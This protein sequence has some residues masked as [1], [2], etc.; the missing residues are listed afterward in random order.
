MMCLKIDFFFKK[1]STFLRTNHEEVV[2]TKDVVFHPSV[3]GPMPFFYDRR[4][5][6]ELR[7]E[8][9]TFFV[10]ITF[11]KLLSSDE[12]MFGIRVSPSDIIMN[13]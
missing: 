2:Y 13:L 7:R 1:K 3:Y 4:Y 11:G 12:I 8:G 10:S 6:Q 5:K 9:Y